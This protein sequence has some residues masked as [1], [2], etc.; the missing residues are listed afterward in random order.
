MFRGAFVRRQW[1]RLITRRLCHLGNIGP[2]V[3]F[4]FD[5]FPRT[6]YTVGG[7][8]LKNFGARGTFYA[9]LGLMHSTNGSGEHFLLQDLFSLV[10]D[11]HELASHTFH[12][13]SSRSTP[14]QAFLEEVRE[15]RAAMQR[16]SG[17][18]VSNNFAYP[19]GAISAPAKGVV[20]KEMLSCRGIFEGVNDPLVDLNLLRA[21]SLYGGTDQLG[22][23]R[24]LI[25]DNEKRKGWLIFYTHDV[26]KDPSRYGCTPKLFEL[27]VELVLK[28]G[29]RIL[30]VDKVL[31]TAGQTHMSAG[32]REPAVQQDRDAHTAMRT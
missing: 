27:A 13:V 26:Q 8:V 3:S 23:V 30:T 18:T 22:G 16:I 10:A 2:V 32:A 21:N 29:M 9:S 28:R 11:G 7:A 5:D 12:H 25:D 20:G 17:L 1:L 6:A 15:G 31:G 24:R 4:T 19:F 14:L